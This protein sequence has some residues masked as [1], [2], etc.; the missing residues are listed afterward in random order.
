MFKR[1]YRQSLILVIFLAFAGLFVFTIVNNAQASVVDELK[2]RIS[3]RNIKI[4]ELEK[5]IVQFQKDLEVVGEEKQ[6]LKNEVKRLDISRQKIGAD[7]K[8]TQNKID[9]TNYQ[10]QELSL[11][12]DSKEKSINKNTEVVA[13]TIRA[14]NEVE[15]E[16]LIEM[17][18]SNDNISGFLDQIETLQQ[19]Q[20]KMRDDIKRLTSLKEDLVDRKNQTEKKK[21]ELANFKEDLTDQKY[22]LDINKKD[23]N[24]VLKMTE[25]K[26]S[27]YQ[28]LL[29][30]KRLQK[31]EFEKDLREIESQLQYE[32]DPNKIPSA[33]SGVLL[34]PLEDARNESCYTKK[35]PIKNC[36]TQYFGNTEFAKT[37]AYKGEGHNGVDF[38]ASSGT[39]VRTALSGTVA[40][41][42]QSAI[43]GCQYGKW[44][45]IK[46]NN[47]L[48]TLYAHLSF[49]SD[50]IK[51]G[52]SVIT[53]D[54]IGY[55]GSTGYS[56]GPH[57]HFTVY[58]AEAVSFREYECK[59]GATA[60][61]P[62]ASFNAYLNPL[63]YL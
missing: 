1:T 8:L 20:S 16:S 55:S 47:G 44:I 38:R 36:I 54:T 51:V 30:E 10:I 62:V 34:W 29:E 57:L 58:V 28:K 17:V 48:S 25:N 60:T 15:S 50:K 14:M 24:I 26:E 39:K 41:I 56:L 63:D 5:E 4:Q 18:L 53:G 46:H 40:K 6:T 3:D 49:I 42:N 22:V 45:L 27:N 33:K 7:I 9:S 2:N 59:S 43:Y 37:A 35:N 19:F 31:E 23:K 32:L 61:I 13:E 11:G 21:R 52:Q 12:I